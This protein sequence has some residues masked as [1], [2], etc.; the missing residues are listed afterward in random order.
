VTSDPLNATVQEQAA[1][2]RAA[3]LLGL[4]PGDAVVK[5]ADALIERS[6]GT[7]PRP[8]VD[9]ATTAPDDL[10]TLRYALF[11]VCGEQLPENVIRAILGLVGRD[12]TSG[13]R[14]ARDTVTVLGQMRSFLRLETAMVDELRSIEL[15]FAVAARN[16]DTTLIERQI[17]DW[18]AQFEAGHKTLL[19]Q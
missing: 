8:L 19:S 12:L 5:W 2:Y 15:R 13:R 1:L 4:L 7:V 6:C 10:T 16:G 3:L 17:H 18:L 14:T 11:R 9:I